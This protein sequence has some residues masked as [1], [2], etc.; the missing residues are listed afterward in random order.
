[1]IPIEQCR[2]AFLPHN[3]A[4]SIY[5]IIV[6]ISRVEKGIVVAALELK[7]GLEDFGWNVDE[8]RSKIG[9]ESWIC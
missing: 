2:D 7:A 1:L 8:R 3:G 5:R 9:D 4:S 6:I